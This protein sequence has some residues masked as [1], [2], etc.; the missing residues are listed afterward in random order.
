[1][2]VSLAILIDGHPFGISDEKRHIQDGWLHTMMENLG[3][4]KHDT[5]ASEAIKHDKNIW[6]QSPGDV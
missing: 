4:I 3:Y 5:G 6:L 2:A 1:M